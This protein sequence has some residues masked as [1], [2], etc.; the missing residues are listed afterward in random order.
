MNTLSD[1]VAVSHAACTSSRTPN[2]LSTV[3]SERPFTER[4]LFELGNA[5]FH[6]C[7]SGFVVSKVTFVSATAPPN[8]AFPAILTRGPA[9]RMLLM[10]M[11]L[12]LGDVVML[13]STVWGSV[14]TSTPILSAPLLAE[15][16]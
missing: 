8:C 11:P 3:A 12:P 14:S 5:A 4:Q 13:H 16:M 6:V 7:E 2:V 15:R 10:H 9:P 1:A